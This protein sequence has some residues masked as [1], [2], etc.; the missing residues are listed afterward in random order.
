M[1]ATIK[2]IARAAGIDIRVVSLTLRNHP[3]AKVFREEVRQRV[4]RIANEL[5]Y[6]RNLLAA[7]MRTGI[8]NTVAIV[9]NF[10]EIDAFPLPGVAGI[11]EECARFGYN[12][13]LYPDQNLE[14]TFSEIRGHCLKY[15]LSMSVD[16][17]ERRKTA[18]FC[19]ANQIKLVYLC[20]GPSMGYSAVG[21][22]NFAAGFSAVSFFAEHGHERI[23]L[24]TVPERSYQYIK[25]RNSGYR[26]GMKHIGITPDPGWIIGDGENHDCLDRFLRMEKTKRPTAIFAISDSIAVRLLY[27]V[28]LFGI[29]V[30]EELAVVGFGN[31]S[32]TRLSPVPLAT[33]EELFFERGKLA[34]DIL[35]EKSHEPVKKE[36][37]FYLVEPRLIPLR[38]AGG[39]LMQNET[40]AQ[41]VKG[42]G[43]CP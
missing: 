7:S 10:L 42:K 25:A 26:E 23:G 43:K 5:G 32:M 3:D 22:D 6:E 33:F 14:K 20:E 13:R 35:L 41:N 39:S 30:P 38:S 12:V 28:A 19:S 16:Q 40:V 17:E 29:R 8:V 21:I 37:H 24:A 34:V 15:V 9:G 27:R 18:E 2:D 31:T 4:L 1:A 11:M 36:D